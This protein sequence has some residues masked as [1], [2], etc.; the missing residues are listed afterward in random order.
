MLEFFK[1][2]W[3]WGIFI[4]IPYLAWE[5]FYRDK[6]RL[7][8]YYNRIDLLKSLSSSGSWLRF[9]PVILRILLIATLF[10]SLARPRLANQKQKITGNGIDIILAVDIS[11]SMQA[12]DFRPTNR[13]EAAK[14]VAAE[15]IKKRKNDR[16]GVIVFSDHA[17]TKCPLTLDY[18]ML[19][20]ILGD[21]KIDQE[22]Q[23]T[24]IGMGLATA[25]ARLK[26]SQAKSKVIVLMTDGKDNT[27]QIHPL[28]AA[29]MAATFG[30]K[31]YTI[32]VG[33]KGL[34]DFPY[35]NGYRKVNI[36][37][38]IDILNDIAKTCGTDHARLA[39][40]TEQLVE[41]MDYIDNM[42]KTQIEI[43][44]Y[45][46]YEELFTRWIMLAIALLLLEFIFR[47]FILKQLP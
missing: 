12:V 28:T 6:K 33:R 36:D 20:T 37:F 45:Y 5:I 44:N 13:L 1:P 39:R 10:I 22:A 42:E 23:G 47:F 35:G 17:Y 30:I 7:R 8:L 32:G 46:E 4:C 29:N 27:G 24:A 11:G 15:F 2:D 19:M 41:V 25:V 21:I 34:V 9:I 31:V 16:I 3:L 40:N 38:D 18:N 43:K 14:K 26:D